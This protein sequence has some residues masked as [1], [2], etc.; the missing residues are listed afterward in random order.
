MYIGATAGE[1]K[2]DRKVGRFCGEGR[3]VVEYQSVNILPVDDAG[4]AVCVPDGI[5]AT[6]SVT[7][8]V[9]TEIVNCRMTA[10]M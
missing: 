3:A 6:A 7:K 2:A 4:A 1:V 10:R 9:V 8:F 5:T